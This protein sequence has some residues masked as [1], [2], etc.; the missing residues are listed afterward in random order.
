M[1]L[2][3]RSDEGATVVVVAFAMTVLLGF[4]ALAIDVGFGYNER[5]QDQTVADISVMAGILEFSGSPAEIEAKVMAFANSNATNPITAADWA[6]CTDPG[7]DDFGDFTPL[8]V[9]TPCIS[10]SDGTF[11]RV[12]LPDQITPT[13]FGRLL[14][15]TE[16]RTSAFAIARVRPNQG[17]GILPFGLTSGVGAGGTCLRTG[18]HSI[19]PCTGPETGNFFEINSP[20]KGNDDLGTSRQCTGNINGRLQSNIAIGLDHL[21]TT[22]GTSPLVGD[23]CDEILPPNQLLV[24]T[25]NASI[26]PGLIENGTFG[27]LGTP[28]RLQQGPTAKRAVRDGNQTLNLDNVPLWDYLVSGCPASDFGPAVSEDDK[29]TNMGN[30]LAAGTARFSSAI[31]NSPRLA[32]VPKF[33]ESTWPSGSSALRT[34]ATLPPIFLHATYFNCNG[35]GSCDMIFYPG[36]DTTELCIPQ[37]MGCKNIALEQLTSFVLDPAMLPDGVLPDE[38]PGGSLNTSEAT[39]FR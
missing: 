13:T 36:E 14:G 1:S 18:P 27:A 31:G 29:Y 23:Y 10:A 33:E 32:Q 15:V 6:A 4:A 16:L 9:N 12:N 19:P 34:I 37:G 3:F 30:C 21:V 17:G 20:L 5:R 8:T 26:D 22:H 11:L 7:Q 25:G 39:L 35:T 28:S 24:R 38:G 2:N